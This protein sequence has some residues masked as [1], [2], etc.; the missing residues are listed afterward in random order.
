MIYRLKSR[1]R[2]PFIYM[3]QLEKIIRENHYDIVHIQQNSASM[4]MD[5]IVAKVCGVKAVIGHSHST[6]C[7]VLWQHYLFKPFVNY[8]CDYR[9]ACSTQAGAWVFGNRRDV[10]V[11]N[12]A[13]DTDIYEFDQK[14][15]DRYRAEFGLEDKFA[16]GFVGRL[17]DEKNVFWYLDICRA[18]KDK[19]N[20]AEFVIVGDG[21]QKDRL[22]E[23]AKEKEIANHVDFFGKRNDVPALMMMFDVF[24][25]P[26]LFEGLG[27]VAIEVQ[28]SGLWCVVSDE[29]PASNMAKRIAYLSLKDSDEVWAEKLFENKPFDRQSAKLFVKEN[30]YDIAA[31]AKK[32]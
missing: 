25:I 14:T 26:S 11:I 17:H 19:R 9:V 32:L 15:R 3:K 24:L 8:F 18:V 5:A 22:V 20:N 1:S 13:I 2:K 29:V 4:T 31:E 27:L 21:P 28:A 10:T 23:Y 30:G 7:N 6:S 16:I 12:N